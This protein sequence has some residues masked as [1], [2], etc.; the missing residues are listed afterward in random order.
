MCNPWAYQQYLEYGAV[1]PQ[2][3]D[4][5]KSSGIEA[6]VE[7]TKDNTGFFIKV[8]LPDAV[9]SEESGE[10]WS[11]D[12]GGKVIALGIPVENRDAKAIA[13]ALLKIIGK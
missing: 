1:F 5:L 2:I 10:N 8:M 13:A 7:T 6:K 9:L 4:I 12:L 3:V 11:V